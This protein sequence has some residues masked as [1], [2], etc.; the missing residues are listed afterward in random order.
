MKYFLCFLVLAVASFPMTGL[1]LHAEPQWFYFIGTAILFVTAG[2]IFT[3]LTER[4]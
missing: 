1:Y 3:I 4:N 2:G